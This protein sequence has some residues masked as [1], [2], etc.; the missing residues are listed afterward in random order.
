MGT[1]ID[2]LKKPEAKTL[3][4]VIPVLDMLKLSPE[5]AR[6]LTVLAAALRETFS[7]IVPETWRVLA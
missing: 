3:T 6:E 7:Q 4:I 5:Q 1:T 2:I